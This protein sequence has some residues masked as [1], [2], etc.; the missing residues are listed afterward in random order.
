MQQFYTFFMVFKE[1]FHMFLTLKLTPAGIIVMIL[2]LQN[3][4]SR[5]RN[6][7]EFF[8]FMQQIKGIV[9]NGIHI[10]IPVFFLF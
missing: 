5:V 7:E 4:N 6:I 2:V 8:P 3:R 1:H 9:K 10:S